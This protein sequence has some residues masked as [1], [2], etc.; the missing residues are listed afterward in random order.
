MTWTTLDTAMERIRE[1]VG[2]DP[3]GAREEIRKLLKST[4]PSGRIRLRGLEIVACRKLEDFEAA[5]RAY[6]AG[7]KLRGSVLAVAELEGQAAKLHLDR[8]DLETA[9]IAADRAASLTRSLVVKPPGKSTKVKRMHRHVQHV[10]A[11]ILITRAQIALFPGCQEDLRPFDDVFEALR[12]I[13]PRHSPRVHLAAVSTLAVLLTQNAASLE[14]LRTALRL[15]SEAQ[16]LLRR[17]RVRACHPHRAQLRALR[18]LV[19]AKLGAVELAEHLFERRVIP[20]L[21]AAGMDATA[22]VAAEQLMWIVAE[23]GGKE[24]RACYLRRKHGL[25]PVNVEQTPED[26]GSPIGF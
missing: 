24:G 3:A 19:L 5:L 1:T 8:R 25:Q 9:R 10:F 12:F 4:G 14:D 18:G 23:R 26:D 13:D 21:R 17:R 11:A 22:D 7:S 20:D 15:E 2:E 6:H 16:E